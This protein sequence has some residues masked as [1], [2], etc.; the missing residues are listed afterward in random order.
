MDIEYMDLKQDAIGRARI[1]MVVDTPVS[2]LSEIYAQYQ[3]GKKFVCSIKPYTH[4]KS[5]EQNRYAWALITALANKRRMPKMEVYEEQIKKYG[6]SELFHVKCWDAIETI[7]KVYK[8]VEVVHEKE[9][10]TVYVRAYR[11]LSKLDNVEAAVLIDGIIEDCKEW[12]INPE[13]SNEC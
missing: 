6:Q 1:L 8:F 12:G 2:E 5:L 13:V 11:G 4:K 10:G 9:D 3:S 7:S